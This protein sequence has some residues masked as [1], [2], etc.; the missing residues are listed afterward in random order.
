MDL[1]ASVG[2]E[3]GVAQVDDDAAEPRQHRTAREGLG[4]VLQ[5]DAVEDGDEGE[6]VTL[7]AAVRGYGPFDEGSG[8]HHPAPRTESQNQERSQDAHLTREPSDVLLY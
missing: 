1:Q 4:A 8:G 5:L 3:L 7:L 6:L 2:S